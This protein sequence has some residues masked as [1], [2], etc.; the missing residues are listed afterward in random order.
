MVD[1]SPVRG[2]VVL[3]EPRDAGADVALEASATRSI[4]SGRLPSPTGV[5]SSMR[6]LNLVAM[7]TRSRT[8]ASASPTSSSLT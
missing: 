6:Q 7:T 8:G 2:E 5:P 4:C 1:Q 3:L